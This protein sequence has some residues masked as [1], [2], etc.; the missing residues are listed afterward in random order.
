MPNHTIEESWRGSFV[1]PDRR[2]ITEWASENIR[3]G[4]NSPFPG[5]FNVENVPW[6]KRIYEAFEDESVRRITISGCP[7]KSGKTVAATILPLF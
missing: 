7:Q 2:G 3:F 6:T 4:V 5:P 1:R